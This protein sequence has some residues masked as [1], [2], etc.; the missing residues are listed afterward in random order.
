[1]SGLKS[2]PAVA[3][4]HFGH[5]LWKHVVAIRGGSDGENEVTFTSIRRGEELGTFVYTLVTSYEC[6]CSECF[7]LITRERREAKLREE[8]TQRERERETSV[9][10]VDNEDEILR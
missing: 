2:L 7:P 8:L 4:L 10:K 5:L 9:D 6:C 3:V 1:M